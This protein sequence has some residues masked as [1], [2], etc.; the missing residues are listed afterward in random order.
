VIYQMA[1]E[2]QTGSRPETM[3]EAVARKLNQ[4]K[5]GAMSRVNAARIQLGNLT[6]NGGAD[7]GKKKAN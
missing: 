2:K 6:T 7:A 4:P 3:A 5:P 1:N